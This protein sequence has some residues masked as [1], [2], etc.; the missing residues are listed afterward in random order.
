MGYDE[1]NGLLVFTD[2]ANAR[3]VYSDPTGQFVKETPLGNGGLS[4][5]CNVD[6]KGDFAITASL[7]DGN[8]MSNGEVGIVD[9]R[10]NQVV[11]V[12]EIAKLLSSGPGKGHAHPHDAIFLPNGDVVV[13]TWNP[14]KLSYWV[15]ERVGAINS[16]PPLAQ[17][18]LHSTMMTDRLT[19]CDFCSARTAPRL[20]DAQNGDNIAGHYALH[21]FLHT[22]SSLLHLPLSIL[23][24]RAHLSFLFSL[25]VYFCA[26]P[27]GGWAQAIAWVLR[28]TANEV[29]KASS[30]TDEGKHALAADSE[31][32]LCKIPLRE[33]TSFVH[34]S[35]SLEFCSQVSFAV[36]A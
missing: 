27:A 30:A 18:R 14:G 23:S 22:H 4:L 31:Q 15:R 20:A 9:Q 28:R 19:R 25:A 26:P 13:G 12:L 1:K 35:T 24:A 17:L 3:L 34:M 8:G 5:P 33:C 32:T 21:P 10:T 16:V 11:S 6:V 36:L 7:G 2:R 29:S